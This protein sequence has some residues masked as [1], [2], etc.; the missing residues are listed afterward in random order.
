MAYDTKFEAAVQA[1]TPEQVNAA[2]KKYLDPSKMVT[3]V[4]GDATVLRPAL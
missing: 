1:L 3:V 2:V 4:V